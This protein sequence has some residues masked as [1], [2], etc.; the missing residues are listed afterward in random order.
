LSQQL[1][2]DTD[3]NYGGNINLQKDVNSQN[4]QQ[5]LPQLKLI[6]K[7]LNLILKQLNSILNLSTVNTQST[8]EQITPTT[9][10]LYMPPAIFAPS[11]TNNDSDTDSYSDTNDNYN[12][13]D[14]ENIDVNSQDAQQLLPQSKLI[15]KQLDS[16]LKQLNSIL[17][18]SMQPT[19][20]QT[21]PISSQPCMSPPILAPNVTNN[22]S[23]MNP[24]NIV[25][26]I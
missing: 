4:A 3:V 6:L 5:S 18:P 14:L 21:T 7:Q 17:N 16:A 2:P 26:T 12:E 20:E 11:S 9:S 24:A 1:K 8:V 10:Q 13:N 25:T 23:N 22:S 15:L 19:I